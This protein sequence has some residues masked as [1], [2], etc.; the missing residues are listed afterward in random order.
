MG[1]QLG[2]LAI[3]FLRD[4]KRRSPLLTVFS[5]SANWLPTM[6]RRRDHVIAAPAYTAF[7]MGFS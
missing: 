5:A 6:F 1:G 2:Y 4:Q 7:S 3:G